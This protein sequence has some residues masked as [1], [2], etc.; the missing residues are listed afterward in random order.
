MTIE[1]RGLGKSFASFEAVKDV[2]LT[3]P[4]GQILGFLGP[5]G[6]GKT[7]TVRMLAGLMQPDRGDALL[8]GHSI[9][10]QRRQAKSCLGVMPEGAALF[11]HMTLEE[12]LLMEARV[13]GF[14]QAE[15][16][17]RSCDLLHYTGLWARRQVYA[18]QASVGMRKK[19]G[20]ALAVIH[21]PRVVILDEPFEGLDPISARCIRRLLLTLTQRCGITMLLTSHLLA[22]ME[23]LVDQVAMIQDGKIVRQLSIQEMV[24]AGGNLN[25]TYLEAFDASGDQPPEFSWLP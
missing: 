8:A 25:A 14:S 7:T 6:S 13:R 24:A 20:I 15:A 2:S 9:T 5:N 19:L 21:L 11:P 3:V 18:G 16:Q 22:L 1:L 4:A 23:G 10:Q 12:H 17:Q